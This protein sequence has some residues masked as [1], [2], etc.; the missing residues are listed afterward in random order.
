[1]KLKK[2]ISLLLLGTI[3][4]ISV[5][6]VGVSA[7]TFGPYY[8][9][10][11]GSTG[12][13]YYKYTTAIDTSNTIN[14]TLDGNNLIAKQAAASTYIKLVGT[15][16]CI[17]RGTATTSRFN[18][19][20]L[21]NDPALSS[22]INNGLIVVSAAANY[23]LSGDIAIPSTKTE[24]ATLNMTHIVSKAITATEALTSYG[25]IEYRNNTDTIYEYL[26][27]VNY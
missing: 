20:K 16:A 21:F 22:S 3:L 27:T 7:S 24:E 9:S 17:Y 14:M 15:Y 10:E 1:M 23:Y 18:N 5:L 26:S 4:T 2:L 8:Y 6:S 13:I 12:T 11:S 25:T 19:G